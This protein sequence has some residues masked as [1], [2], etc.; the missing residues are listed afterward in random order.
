MTA[1]DGE[2]H[3]DSFDMDPLKE[4]APP[5]PPTPGPIALDSFAHGIDPLDGLI[6]ISLTDGSI[7][8]SW[9]RA[10]TGFRAEDVAGL[11]REAYRSCLQASRR[12]AIFSTAARERALVAE[13]IVTLETLSRTALL[14]RI[15]AFVVASL[16]DASMPLGMARLC[17]T[18]LASALEP[19]LPLTEL[20]RLTL[21]PPHVPKSE[22]PSRPPPPVGMSFTGTLKV[23][24]A[25]PTEVERVRRVLAYAESNLPDGHTV[26]AR[27]ALRAH[28]SRLSLDHP[29]TLASDAVLRTEAAALEMLGLDQDQLLLALGGAG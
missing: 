6:V 16:F 11:L 21:P 28:T 1:S 20:E 17:A 7:F 13:P 9:V 19:E 22:G 29:E 5:P 24:L 14:K 10:D 2:K 26:R 18:R 15:R 23:A 8:G 3:R 25:T 12:L 4:T 27:L